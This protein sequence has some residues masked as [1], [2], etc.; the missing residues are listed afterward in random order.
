MAETAT[1]TSKSIKPNVADTNTLE[2]KK[3]SMHLEW[4]IRRNEIKEI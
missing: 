4:Q 3:K 1:S 2:D